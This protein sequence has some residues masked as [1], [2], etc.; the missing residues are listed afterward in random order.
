MEDYEGPWEGRNSYLIF[1]FY[2]FYPRSF[3]GPGAF[4]DNCKVPAAQVDVDVVHKVCSLVSLRSATLV[5]C[6]MVG[7]A[8]KIWRNYGE[9]DGFKIICGVDGSLYT[10][11]PFFGENLKKISK[12]LLPEG[13]NLE[14]VRSHD[15]SGKGAALMAAGA[16]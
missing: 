16:K 6:A 5:A 10:K 11:H 4:L 2:I 13:L 15:A 1:G 12:G 7:L 9:E 14:F 8:I 3:F